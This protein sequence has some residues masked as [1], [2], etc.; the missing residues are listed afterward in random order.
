MLLSEPL[1]FVD[2]PHGASMMLQIDSFVDGSAV[3]HPVN[4]S[5]RHVRIHMQQQ[6]LSVA[7]PNGTPIGVEIPVLRLF[8]RR[9]DAASSQT[10]FDVSSKRLRADLLARLTNRDQTPLVVTLTA[11]GQKPTKRYSVEVAS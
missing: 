4:P 8:G 1:E 9:L 2:L 3:I 6:S 11:K 7:P 5:P 10:Y